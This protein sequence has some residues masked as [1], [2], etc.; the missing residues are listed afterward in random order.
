MRGVYCVRRH[1]YLT[2]MPNSMPSSY[3]WSHYSNR[4]MVSSQSSELYKNVC[5]SG[6]GR[7][8]CD[9]DGVHLSKNCYL[10]SLPTLG[11]LFI[12]VLP[13][14]GHLHVFM[15]SAVFQVQ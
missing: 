3:G 8:M 13:N 6:V 9:S 14:M 15:V 12:L 4:D 5:M 1:Q 10:Q 2:E 7:V 11:S